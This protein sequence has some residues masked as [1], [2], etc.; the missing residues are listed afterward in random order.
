MIPNKCGNPN[1]VHMF[2]YKDM[3][4]RLFK[5]HETVAYKFFFLNGTSVLSMRPAYCEHRDQ[6]FGQR[7]FYEEKETPLCIVIIFEKTES[8]L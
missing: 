2:Q 3:G 4:S 8:G 6:M 7:K 5:Y 1:I